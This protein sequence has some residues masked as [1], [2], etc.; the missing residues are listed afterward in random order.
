LPIP[1][2]LSKNE[3]ILRPKSAG[4]A[5]DVQS[6]SQSIQRDSGGAKRGC[7][8]SEIQKLHWFNYYVEYKE[9][10][11]QSVRLYYS[12]AKNNTHSFSTVFLL[13]AAE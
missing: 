2:Q 5:V 10:T 8:G 9:T 12:A 11:L 6:Q 7:G 1:Q 4:A 13:I 3:E